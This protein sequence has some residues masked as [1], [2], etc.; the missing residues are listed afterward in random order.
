MDLTIIPGKLSGEVNI[1][2]S[3]SI[4]HRA[5]ICAALANGTSDIRNIT[6]SEDIQATMDVLTELGASFKING[7]C[8]TVTGIDTPAENAVLRCNESG[9]TLRFMIPVACALGTVS[10]FQGKGRLPKR[11][12]DIYTRELSDKGVIFDYNNDMPFT[13]SGKLTGGE[14]HVE[15]DVSSQFITGLLLALP[16]CPEDSVIK[17]TSTLQSRPYVDITINCLKRFGIEIHENENEYMIKG[18]QKYH[19][20]NFDVEADFSQAAFFITA[21]AIGNNVTINNLPD[22]SLSSQGDKK[23]IEIAESICYNKKAGVF[24]DITIDASDIP[25]LVPI[26][27]V[28][29]SLSGCRTFITNAQRLRIK[30]SDRLETTAQMINNLGGNVTVTDDGLIISPVEKFTGGTVHSF[31]D[32]RIAM[33]TAIAASA[34]DGRVFIKNFDSIKKSYPDFLADYKKLGGKV[35]NGIVLE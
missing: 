19:A 15:G 4:S 24:E 1:P 30:E 18:N 2:A 16:L 6:M 33:A 8:I 25:D 22:A 32:H 20:E 29:C 26:V 23:I 3:K 31:N 17:L 9:S 21:N 28:L 12:I 35:Q 14:F 13:V 7:N 10:E 27:S 11:P 34:A 5:L